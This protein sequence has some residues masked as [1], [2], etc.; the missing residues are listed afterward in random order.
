MARRLTGTHQ[1]LPS[2]DMWC[3]CRIGHGHTNSSKLRILFKRTSKLLYS[4]RPSTSTTSNQRTGNSITQGFRVYVADVT[5]GYF[6]SYEWQKNGRLY[7]DLTNKSSLE[8]CAST[9]VV[10]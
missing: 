8:T 7:T 3:V 2:T 4:I 6:P 10:K 5:V 1:L 9:T